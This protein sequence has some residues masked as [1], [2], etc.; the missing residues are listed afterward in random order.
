[1]GFVYLLDL[2]V[3]SRG[4]LQR[5]SDSPPAA[6]EGVGLVLLPLMLIPLALTGAFLGAMVYH[7]WRKKH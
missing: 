6:A 5:S 3:R 2:A 1:M 7:L 4:G